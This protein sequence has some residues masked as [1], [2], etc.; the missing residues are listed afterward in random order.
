MDSVGSRAYSR[1]L[2]VLLFQDLSCLPPPPPHPTLVKSKA[3]Q[4]L[5]LFY[6]NSNTLLQLFVSLVCPHLEHMPVLSHK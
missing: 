4:V 2:R 1:A 6:S 3:C 5:G